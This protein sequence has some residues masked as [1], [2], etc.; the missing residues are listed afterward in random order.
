[1]RIVSLACSNTEI[2]AALGCAH[3]L[4]GV[5]DHSDYPAAALR[6]IPRV[7]PDLQIDVDAVVALQPDLV[8]ASLTVPGHETVVEGVEAAGL[9]ILTLAPERLDDVP[10]TV[11]RIAEAL[12]PGVPG[13]RAR[14]TALA[15]ELRAA[16]AERAGEA[17]G[18]RTPVVGSAA[19]AAAPPSS[20]WEA[21]PRVLVQWWPKPVIAPGSRSWVHAMIER[22]GGRNALEGEDHLSRPLDDEGVAALAP[23]VIVL[24]WCGVEPARYRPEVVYR[25]PAFQRVPAI[26]HGRVHRIPEAWMGRPG[27]R[28][29]DGIAAL[30]RAVGTVPSPPIPLSRELDRA[31]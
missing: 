3:L 15:G 18:P 14:G 27:P 17:G 21:R 26:R 22:A 31:L 8:L 1:M 5:D 23:D 30:R 16:F 4:V 19:P 20:A 13:V 2:V 6:G 7:G 9:P 25:N 24:S 11:E 29:V 10:P 12:A 28:L